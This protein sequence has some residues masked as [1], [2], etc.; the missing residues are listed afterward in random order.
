MAMSSVSGI[1][2][3]AHAPAN[4]APA[5]EH[6]PASAPGPRR[7]RPRCE[8][9]GQAREAVHFTPAYTHTPTNTAPAPEPG[10]CA[11]LTRSRGKPGTGEWCR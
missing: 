10:P 8:V 9:P 11:T 2:G 4:T 3:G 6:A 5:S 7:M 1:A